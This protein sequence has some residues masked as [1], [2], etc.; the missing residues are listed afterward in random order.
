MRE[1]LADAFGVLCIFATGYAL[2][3]LAAAFGG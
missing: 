2:L 1:Y 3:V